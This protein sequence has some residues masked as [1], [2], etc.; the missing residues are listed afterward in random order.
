VISFRPSSK[1][2]ANT[3][4]SFRLVLQESDGPGVKFSYPMDVHV[5]GTTYDFYKEENFT[6]YTF[7]MGALDRYGNTSIT[8]SNPINYP[9]LRDNWDA[10]FDVYIK[11]V[12]IRE[13]NQTMP[14]LSWEHT[15]VSDDNKTMHFRARFHDP[16][17]LGLL[18]KKSDRLYIHFKY[19]LLDFDG[20]FKRES[21]DD[22]TY[23]EGMYLNCTDE[24]GC[25]K[26]NATLSRVFPTACATD[27]EKSPPD[28]KDAQFISTKEREKLY[29]KKRIDIQFDFENTEMMYMRK[30]AEKTY[31]YLCGVVVF[32]YLMLAM[33]N[34]G[35][36]PLWTLIEYMQLCA[37]IPL[38]NFRMIP[39]LYDAF[40]PFLVSHLVLTDEAR[41]LKEF[42]N[43]Y[44]NINYDYFGL[45]IAKLAQALAL[46][47]ILGGII[48]FI[49]IVIFAAWMVT[50][51][52]TKVG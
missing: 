49:N 50:P 11:N 13:H 42:E 36:L 39:Y 14:L 46:V 51:R 6:D 24:Y 2:Y 32:Q 40:K 34:I 5:T 38:Y 33:R 4:Y 18:T 7:E 10:M 21:Y 9:F 41:L 30:F 17:M 29:K 8:W 43:D 3:T 52:D 35:F 27:K 23:F 16:Y 15:G 1:W 48:I 20:H 45:N 31:W 44:F 25:V 12:T 28:N 19:D 37:F 26:P 22:K 47:T